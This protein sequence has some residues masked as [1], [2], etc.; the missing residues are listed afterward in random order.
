MPTNFTPFTH[1]ELRELWALSRDMLQ[2]FTVRRLILSAV[3][4][5]AM[6]D[7]YKHRHNCTGCAVCVM[8]DE[9]WFLAKLR[10]I[11]IELEGVK[12]GD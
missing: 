6:L 9:Y 11:G 1:E 5:E 7:G 3:W 4:W 2:S 10:E 8:D 12:D